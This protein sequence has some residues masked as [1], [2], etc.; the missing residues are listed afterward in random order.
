M[1]VANTGLSWGDRISDR[2]GGDDTV[3]TG[4]TR[5]ESATGNIIY[6]ITSKNSTEVFNSTNRDQVFGTG[7]TIDNSVN[8]AF[9][10]E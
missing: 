4:N 1:W 8:V 2:T 3:T 9:G 6:P 5:F 10:A 7:I